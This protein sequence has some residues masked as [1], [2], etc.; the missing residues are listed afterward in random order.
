MP[1]KAGVPISW[2]L[3]KSKYGFVATLCSSCS[4]IFFPPRG[5]CPDC[6]ERT[7]NKEISGEG[8][9]VSYTTI[10]T[11]PEGFENNTP[12]HIALINLK[13]GP[14]ISSQVIG[15]IKI[16]SKVIPTFRRITEDG[17][18]GHIIYGQKFVV[19]E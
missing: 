14:N 7:I 12:Y 8:E 2:R 5:V 11:A 13:E 19:K 6:N 18:T 17:K 9:V 15:S 16:G 3:K 10:H 1:H 4:K